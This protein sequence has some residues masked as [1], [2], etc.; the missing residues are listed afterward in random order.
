MRR[1][2][3]NPG[4]LAM[5]H[6]TTTDEGNRA[7]VAAGRIDAWVT[8]NEVELVDVGHVTSGRVAAESASITAS[9]LRVVKN[10]LAKRGL[11]LLCLAMGVEPG[12]A[13][14]YVSPGNGEKFHCQI[15][16]LLCTPEA[17]RHVAP[18]PQQSNTPS[19]TVLVERTAAGSSG[20]RK[21]ASKGS[22]E[23]RRDPSS[24]L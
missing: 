8:G 1:I 17:V 2:A 6:V 14:R 20:I 7:H 3:V 4:R 15:G 10:P 21:V 12:R 22:F 16:S 23:R 18:R 13:L 9:C 11:I 19:G 24:G 5:P